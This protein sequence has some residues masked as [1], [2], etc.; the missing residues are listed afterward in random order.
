MSKVT[1]VFMTTKPIITSKI[2][3]SCIGMKEY[4]KIGVLILLCITPK[5]KGITKTI[6]R[7]LSFLAMD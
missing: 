3:L 2:T 6:K 5:E 7:T 1:L 4:Q